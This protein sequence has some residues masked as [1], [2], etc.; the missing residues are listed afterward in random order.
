MEALS[1]GIVEAPHRECL[2]QDRRV[3]EARMHIEQQLGV[4]GVVA[5]AGHRVSAVD[6]GVDLVDRVGGGVRLGLGAEGHRVGQ[7]QGAL[8]AFPRV[9]LV[10]GG[11]VGAGDHEGM[12]RVHQQGPRATEEHGDL[13]VHLP[14]D[15]CGSEVAAVRRRRHT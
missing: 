12:G 5:R 6:A 14:R 1:P 3:D 2:E 13:A 9:P 7:D 15:A 8:Q 11:L 10:H 4:E